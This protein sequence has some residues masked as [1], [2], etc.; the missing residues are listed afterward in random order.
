MPL[1]RCNALLVDPGAHDHAHAHGPA[2]TPSSDDGDA[3]AEEFYD[4]AE[5][6]ARP[7]PLSPTTCT[8]ATGTYLEIFTTLGKTIGATAANLHIDRNKP[9]TSAACK[10]L[11]DTCTAAART[12]SVTFSDAHEV[13]FFRK[14]T[15]F[16]ARNAQIIRHKRRSYMANLLAGFGRSR[17]RSR[18]APTGAGAVVSM[19]GRLLHVGAFPG[20]EEDGGMAPRR[21]NSPNLDVVGSRTLPTKGSRQRG[22]L[23]RQH[24]ADIDHLFE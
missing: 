12:K 7:M 17:G 21:S 2:H 13:V 16:E 14:D 15:K 4:C 3:D 24:T 18:A 20:K 8:A 6:F 19:Q 22:T 9:T 10:Q 11:K 23:S 1:A 5:F